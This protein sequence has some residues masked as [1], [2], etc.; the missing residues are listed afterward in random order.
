MGKGL[1]DL[2]GHRG[3]DNKTETTHIEV[4]NPLKDLLP[5]RKTPHR[6]KVFS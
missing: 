1:V 2:V 3:L 6:H 5:M 4:Y